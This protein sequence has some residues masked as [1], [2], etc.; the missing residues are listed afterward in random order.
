MASQQLHPS[1]HHPITRH[2]CTLPNTLSSKSLIY[3]IFLTS[4]PNQK[5]PIASLPDQYR[6]GINQLIRHLTPLIAKGLSSVLL[7]GVPLTKEKDNQGTCATTE[8]NPILN[9]IKVLKTTFPKL[10]IIVDVCLCAYT[11]HGHCG[12][13]NELGGIDNDKSIIRIAEVAK[14]Y[15]EAGADVIAPR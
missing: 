1:I 15:A 2:W 14:C 12:V 5:D 8:E 4:D 3:P 9:G 11:S 7:F 10:L 6:Y 13:L